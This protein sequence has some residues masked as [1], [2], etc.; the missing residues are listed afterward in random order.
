M[1]MKWTSPAALLCSAL[2][3]GGC[4]DYRSGK[5]WNLDDSSQWQQIS[6]TEWHSNACASPLEITTRK[7]SEGYAHSLFLIPLGLGGSA[8]NPDVTRFYA[9]GKALSG[10]CNSSDLVMQVNGRQ[11]ADLQISACEVT[12]DCCVIDIPINRDQMETLQVSV[13]TPDAQCRYAP[14]KLESGSHM[15]LRGTRFGGSE[16][17]DW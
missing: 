2:L 6:S 12:Q 7:A 17:C 11:P 8:D 13:N 5:H 10:H 3:L 9:V 16:G 14:L 1:N 4:Y 15:C